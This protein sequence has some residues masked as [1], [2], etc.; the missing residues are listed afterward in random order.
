M[1]TERQ[2]EANRLNALKSTGPRTVEGKERSRS[3]A[4]TH[5]MPGEG[6]EAKLNLA[7]EERRAAWEVTY[8]PEG[9]AG[10]WALER[11][12]A[13][14][15]QIERCERAIDGV[16]VHQAERAR[17][18]WETDRR[19]EAAIVAAKLS[20]DPFVVSR[21]L[22]TSRH[23]CELMRDL[24]LKLGEAIDARGEWT[25]AQVSLA[26][27]LLGIPVDLRDGP[28]PLDPTDGVNPVTHRLGIVVHESRRLERLQAEALE[29][30][31][32]L[33]RR[34]A[35]AGDTGIL[36]KP[37]Q[38]LI[39]YQRDAW[40]RY[41]EAIRVLRTSNETN[42]RPAP[43]EPKHVPAPKP[44]PS[45]SPRQ[46]PASPVSLPLPFPAA[47]LSPMS[48]DLIDDFSPFPPASRA[49]NGVA[50]LDFCVGRAGPG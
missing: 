19:L 21:R 31:D 14:S 10:A 3:N 34:Q 2:I 11:A 44:E 50:H 35:E 25:E 48:R 32:N 38:L 29:P 18:A 5:G 22:E 42:T 16:I 15:F 1:A 46:V 17:V 45:R 27:D 8:A 41:R 6:V 13:A 47:T 26:L 49:P 12:V 30:L 33:D 39:R 9:E 36:S 37:A 23:G 28:S 20:N 24:W 43:A 40:R 7:F 4:L